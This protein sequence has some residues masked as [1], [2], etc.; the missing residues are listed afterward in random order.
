[1]ATVID[2]MAGE[3]ICGY[4]TPV[5][6]ADRLAAQL[7]KRIIGGSQDDADPELASPH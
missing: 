6:R 4:A 5:L 3:M 2:L 1:V 7:S